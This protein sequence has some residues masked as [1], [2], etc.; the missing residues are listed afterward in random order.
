MVNVFKFFSLGHPVVIYLL[1]CIMCYVL[2]IMYLSVIFNITIQ[3]VLSDELHSCTFRPPAGHLQVTE[4][5][6]SEIII[7]T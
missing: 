7:V 5:R 1:Q 4:V 6:I 2:R 3:Y